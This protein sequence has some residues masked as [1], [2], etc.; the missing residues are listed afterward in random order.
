MGGSQDKARHHF[1]KAVEYSEGL[2]ASPYVALASTVSV[3]NQ[4]LEEFR[5]LLKAAIAIDPDAN[6][7]NRLQNL[8]SQEKARWLLDHV[9]DFFLL[10]LEEEPYEEEIEEGA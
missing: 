7:D 9:E 6:P 8:L 2:S 10:D 3:A 1:E 4:D 5:Q